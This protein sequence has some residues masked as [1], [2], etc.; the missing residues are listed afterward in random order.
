MQRNQIIKNAVTAALSFMAIG[1]H[2]SSFALGLSDTEVSSYLGQNLKASVNILGANDLKDKACLCLGPNSDLSHVNLS[3][4]AV[5][6]EIA[7]LTITTNHN[8]NEPIVNFSLVAGC[9][10]TIRRDY[11][12]L[13]D[14]P[15][16]TLTKKMRLH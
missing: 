2:T 15:V 8:I 6:G 7:K 14:P 3:L 9:E 1:V 13:L 5:Q 11:V 16:S 10:S 12:L 4:G